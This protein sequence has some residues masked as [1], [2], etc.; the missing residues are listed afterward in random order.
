MPRCGCDVPTV[1]AS[2]RAARL[3]K[4]AEIAT[5]IAAEITLAASSIPP[6]HPAARHARFSLQRR[7]PERHAHRVRVMNENALSVK[8]IRV[9]DMQIINRRS[10]GLSNAEHTHG[11]RMFV[12]DVY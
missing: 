2:T 6:R 3:A 8:L 5:E 12:C 9:G 11:N 4:G 10:S 1:T 7:R